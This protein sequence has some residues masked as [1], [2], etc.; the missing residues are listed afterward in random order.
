[1]ADGSIKI[2]TK[3]DNSGLSRQ[4]NQTRASLQG[5]ATS[6]RNTGAAL[7]VAL[8]APIALLSGAAIKAASDLEESS[9]KVKVVFG[10][11][12]GAI[13][14]FAITSAKNLGMSQQ[15]ALE[16]AGTFGNL[17]V[18][19]GIG[20]QK[21][22][23]MSEGILT[24]ASDLASFNNIKPE[25]A[26]EKL[27]AGLVGE[28]E[29][30]RTLGVN[31]TAAAVE[32]EALA[33]T[34][35][36]AASE[37]TT[38]DKAM[39]SYALI[40]KQT[41]T[42][43]GDFARTS[44][45]LANQQRIVTAQIADM[46]A[47]MGKNLLPFVL[48]VTS[49]LSKFV[50]MFSGM[51][52]TT[53]TYLLIMGAVVAILPVAALGFGQVLKAVTAVREG[54]ALLTAAQRAQAAAIGGFA[55][56]VMGVFLAINYAMDSAAESYN[57]Y[58]D[59]LDAANLPLDEVNAAIKENKQ[60]VADMNHE[61]TK[62][63]D[64]LKS[65]EKATA[66][67]G[68]PETQGAETARLATI[69][70]IG[71]IEEKIEKSQQNQLDLADRLD[72]AHFGTKKKDETPIIDTGKIDTYIKSLNG[73]GSAG[74]DAGG[75]VNDAFSD[76]D[77]LENYYT[78]VDVV[79]NKI[80]DGQ[81]TD[82]EGKKEILDLTKQQIQALYDMGYT[83]EA[84]NKGSTKLGDRA[85]KMLR[86]KVE[87]LD[88]VTGSAAFL[89]GVGVPRG[90]AKG[91]QAGLHYATSAV[92]K[93][94]E[95][96]A[97]AFDVGVAIFAGAFD[98]MGWMADFDPVE[99][100]NNV[101]SF[102]TGLLNFFENDIGAIPILVDDIIGIIIKL[103]EKIVEKMP[104]FLE[105]ISN[106]IDS[107]VQ[108]FVDNAPTLISSIMSLITSV[109][110]VLLQKLPDI[111][112]ALIT[113]LIAFL[114]SFG[115]SANGLT[116]ALCSAI[117]GIIE[118]LAKN[119]PALIA[120]LV[121]IIVAIFNG[122]VDNLPQI[123]DALIQLIVPL[124]TAIMDAIP[125]I[126]EAVV[127]ALPDIIAAIF[128][129]LPKLIV[130]LVKAV[131]IM[132]AKDTD[133]AIN[134][135]VMIAKGIIEGIK[136]AG[137]NIWDAV[138]SV[139][140]KFVDKVKSFFRIASPSKLFYDFGVNIIK[141]MINGIMS[142]GTALITAFSNIFNNIKGLA[143]RLANSFVSI[144]TAIGSAIAN[145]VTNSLERIGSAMTGI[146]NS[147]TS[148]LSNMMQTFIDFGQRFVYSLISGLA[149]GAQGLAS[150]LTDVLQSAVNNL[151]YN[152]KDAVLGWVTD[153]IRGLAGMTA[154]VKKVAWDHVK[155]VAKVKVLG[156]T[157]HLFAKGTTDAPGGM[158]IVGEE[159]PEMI[160]LPKHSRVYT[161][162]ETKAMMSVKNGISGGSNLQGIA[163]TASSVGTQTINL[164][165]TI[166][167]NLTV[168]GRVLGKIAFENIDRY[169]RA[170]YGS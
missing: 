91:I 54:L 83:E 73:L 144:G 17:F 130:E 119:L 142:M 102:T 153:A 16:A 162:A 26:L 160:E 64:L 87:N 99:I 109:I 33:M 156:H 122:L 148:A 27:R 104:V 8:S 141:G 1:M 158:A 88:E 6:L 168:D 118:L 25:E 21:A 49:A 84:A 69:R 15:A 115:D 135:G 45:G 152:L 134:Y 40:L 30:L 39:A 32:T 157:Y 34:Q 116:D 71:D 9:N 47:Q 113:G 29:P 95:M 61:L 159:G 145:G 82:A 44:D 72:N 133:A 57:K 132:A 105:T 165:N 18:A 12:S 103:V 169:Y 5:M 92:K 111:F 90:V 101:E 137:A 7:S 136:R 138:K 80:K 110:K 48:S 89:V 35:K 77:S 108:F 161:A 167:G 28:T 36:K 124:V 163:P 106:V 22:A 11:A 42:A 43:Q 41:K 52:E 112:N 14:A 51:S 63:R 76:V 126:V 20:Q 46:A 86:Q 97:K 98:V 60:E 146:L 121:V 62:Q 55:A 107:L 131:F 120:A 2:D 123:L 81:L 93:T 70:M 140:T 13:A 114:E 10:S 125:V 4:L 139:F 94:V 155:S 127:R 164:N 58:V 170:A 166:T 100:F 53:K 31:L 68:K 129:A 23:D 38:A 78:A 59:K 66:E 147:M 128:A 151:F 19:M 56:L 117:V 75:S 96:M 85:L 154:A 3:I 67:S 79:N 143:S 37:L 24:L 65:I 149:E 150:V 74:T 50:T